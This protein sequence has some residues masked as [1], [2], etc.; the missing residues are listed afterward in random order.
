MK[1]AQPATTLLSRLGLTDAPA[2]LQF[3]FRIVAVVLAIYVVSF[4]LFYPELPTNLDEAAYVVQTHLIFEGGGDIEQL[5]AF[6]GETTSV[7]LGTYP[8]GIPLLMAPFFALFGW[9][10]PFAVPCI[11][12]IIAVAGTAW[13]VSR[14]KRSPVFALL[15]MGFPALLV[16]GRVAMSDVPSAAVVV[17]GWL[18]FW[19][20]A[21]RRWWWWLA[22]GFV[23]GASWSVR[24]SNPMLFLPLFAGTVVRREMKS[25]ALVVGGLA[26]LSVRVISQKLFFG[27]AWFE[28]S[29]YKF[30]PD[31]LDERIGL[32][33]L[34]LLFFVPGGLILSLCYRGRRWPEVVSTIAIFVSLY[35]LQA[36]STIETAFSKRV[37]LALRYLLPV[38]PIIVFAMS[39][40]VP[41]LWKRWMA[42]A[43]RERAVW[44]RVAAAG[45]LVWL[46]AIG[47]A[48]AAVHPTFSMWSA[49]QAEL[50][51]AI[52]DHVP[53]DAVLVTN[54]HGTRKFL[55]EF[56]RTYELI[57]TNETPPERIAELLG[58]HDEVVLALMDRS[59]SD[60]WR[61][62]GV[63]N[64]DYRARV[65]AL[66]ELLADVRPT[67]TD[68]LR[69]WRLTADPSQPSDGAPD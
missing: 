64:D 8:L 49:T 60:W 65:P 59:D 15:M 46:G 54:K 55:R 20:G 27:D 42:G 28:R 14:E 58:R 56:G 1:Q 41:R 61:N 13:W 3:G 63:I 40:S 43:S 18:L 62:V 38:L 53:H 67:S 10:G 11:A 2:D 30:S 17:V 12:V 45:I 39:E 51:K 6:T 36:Y 33:L 47:V 34:G 22:S 26:G 66:Q 5:D 23:A 48:S 7:R 21:D 37:V 19:H 35:L 31:T 52:R 68:R 32:Y 9:R 44:E 69:I 29:F 50:H 24:A 4:A 16:L 57:D 25:A